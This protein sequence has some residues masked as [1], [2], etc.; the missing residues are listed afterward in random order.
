ME[1]LEVFFGLKGTSKEVPKTQDK[2]VLN[3][4]STHLTHFQNQLLKKGLSFAPSNPTSKRNSLN[5]DLTQYHRRL[6][7]L[8]YFGPAPATNKK[9]FHM[10]SDW[11]PEP[12]KLPQP[13]LELIKKDQQSIAKLRETKDRPNL[14]KEEEKALRDLKN[15]SNIIIKPADKG[16]AIVIMDRTDYVKEAL[17]Q[18]HDTKYYQPLS[19]PIKDE[20]AHQISLILETLKKKHYLTKKQCTYLKGQAPYRSRLFYFLPK[21]HKPRQN[22]I[23]NIPPGRPIISDCGSES[24][25]IA[26]YLDSFLTP[27]S[28]KHAS[29]LKDTTDFIHKIKQTVIKEPIKLFTMDVKSLYTN[30]DIPKGMEIMSKWLKKYPDP[31]RPDKE[32]LDLLHLSLTRNDFEFNDKYYLQIKGTAMGKRFAPAYANIYMAEW[33]ETAFHKCK[34]LPKKYYRYLDDIWGVWTHSDKDFEDFT[35]VLNNHHESIEIDPILHDNEVNFLDTTVFKGPNFGK[36]GIL[37]TKVY[38]KPTDTHALLHKK[39]FHPPH[40][41]KGLLKSQLLRFHRICSNPSDRVKATRTLMKTL[42]DR[43]YTRTF[44]RE[45][46]KTFLVPKKGNPSQTT[47]NPDKVNIIPLVSTYSSYTTNANKVIKENFQ[48]TLSQ[49]TIPTK[50]KII[51]AYRK[52]PN[53]KDILVRAKLHP[54]GHKSKNLKDQTAKNKNTGSTITLPSRIPMSQTNCVYLIQC[55]KCP[56]KYVGETRNS[57][58]ARLSNHKYNIT[59]GHKKQTH[60]VQHFLKHGFQ[61]L[62]IRGLEHDPGWNTFQRRRTEKHWIQKLGTIHPF[63]LNEK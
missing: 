55:K 20:T 4:S 3:L 41:F 43:G 45:T 33:E 59:N 26:E 8:A 46:Q 10:S 6:K 56:Q 7:L 19:K 40:V 57:L 62:T 18:L 54:P 29:Y 48:K 61:N 17:R 32:I 35:Q 27:L 30:I 25:G 21:I 42:R 60:L 63:G 23:D 58:K 14:T 12:S 49:T 34:K 9:P 15:N 47:E 37:D 52:N 50:Y 11:E 36:T 2:E 22:W 24:Y 13:I 5:A 1:K 28:N 38:F 44:L 16:S 39:S 51:S 53:L 31:D